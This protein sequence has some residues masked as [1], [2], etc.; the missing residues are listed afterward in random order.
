MVPLFNAKC[1]NDIYD[2]I[3]SNKQDKSKKVKTLL[4]SEGR[5]LIKCKPNNIEIP[6]NNP[7]KTWKNNFD[8]EKKNIARTSTVNISTTKYTNKNTY[9][10]IGWYKLLQDIKVCADSKKS[11]KPYFIHVMSPIVTKDNK[12]NK[13]RTDMIDINWF[14]L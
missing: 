2:S 4:I 6:I 5:M 3:G 13:L 12:T 7:I 14:K 8:K 9:K 10:G 11:G 1:L